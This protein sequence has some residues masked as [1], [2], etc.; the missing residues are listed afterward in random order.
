MNQIYQN[1]MQ[2]LFEHYSQREDAQDNQNPPNGRKL[3]F[4]VIDLK[5]VSLIL[6]DL[7]SCSDVL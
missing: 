3:D 2:K 5:N 7:F 6:S 1:P 4:E